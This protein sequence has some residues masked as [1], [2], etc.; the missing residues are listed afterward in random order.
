[1]GTAG[2]AIT[3]SGITVAIGLCGLL[4]FQGSFLASMGLAAAIAVVL[5]V[6]WALTFLP[7]LM[8]VLGTRVNALRVPFLG[9]PPRT[10]RGLFHFLATR[11]MGRPFF[12]LVPA[13][14]VLAIIA[15][16]VRNLSLAQT[17]IQGLPPQAES[18]VGF[19]MLQNNFPGQTLNNFMVVLDYGSGNPR[20]S[21]NVAAL[22]TYEQSLAQQPG[23]ISP[24]APQFGSH[25]AV[26]TVGSHA[27][28]QS[29]QANTLLSSIRG[30][31]PPPGTR[32]L[33]TGATA[34]N[35][36]NTNYLL[37]QVPL[38]LGFVV[39]AT[40]VLLFLLL[41][42][43]VLPLKAVLTNL[44]S[45]TA[46]F[47]ALVFIFVQGNFSGLLNFTPQPADPL[48]L[49]LLFAVM[50]GLSMDY[51][52]FLLSRIQEYYRQSG[53]TTAAVAMG[54]ERSGRLITGA[55]GIMIG[56][57]LVFGV[58]AHTVIIKE[59]GIGL[60]IAVAVDA[61]VVRLI[62]VPA[63]MRLLGAANWWAPKPL[64]RLHQRL[65]LGEAAGDRSHLRVVA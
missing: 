25:I 43:V 49:A 13:L 17:G 26:L 18:R 2:R 23:A 54:L 15:A 55:A 33:V 22:N 62:V 42:S 31:T 52:V 64:A 11:V 61:T 21:Q 8:A 59:I 47:G 58:L 40:Y 4:F 27:A 5:A 16:P 20:S 29:S 51:E 38:A 46:A 28:V 3:F 45:I 10:D 34:I 24:S 19:D 12:A 53:D 36:D 56:V 65:G 6:I 57:F 9:R 35:T 32:A 1:V 30:L 39:L 60:T 48:V 14:L 37:G 63:V 44:L 41:G 50:Y 7:A